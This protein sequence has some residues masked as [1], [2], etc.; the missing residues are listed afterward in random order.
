VFD[1]RYRSC[2]VDHSFT[3]LRFQRS[4]SVYSILGVH[5]AKRAKAWGPN[6][7]A[8]GPEG[9]EFFG[10]GCSPPHQLEGM[11][12]AVSSPSGVRGEALATSRFRVFYR[13]TKP[14]LLSI[15]LILNLFYVKFSWGLSH[16]RPYN[17]IFVGIRA[18][19]VG[20]CAPKVPRD[21]HLQFA[22]SQIEPCIW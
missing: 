6:S 19:K 10:M 2:I 17:H 4:R 11:G 9:V 1:M 5:E 13:L 14:L 20:I 3:E 12:S 8:R 7:K 18:P 15:L 16:R 21:Q 22:S